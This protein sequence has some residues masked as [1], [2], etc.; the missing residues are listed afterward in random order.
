MVPSRFG[1][2]FFKSVRDFTISAHLILPFLLII[3]FS[4][5]QYYLFSHKTS[6][7]NDSMKKMIGAY[8]IEIIDSDVAGLCSVSVSQSHTQFDSGLV[9]FI[10]GYKSNK[11]AESI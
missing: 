2:F 4:I 1:L 7:Q 11:F 10:V 3:T 5:S 6:I 9:I 8:M